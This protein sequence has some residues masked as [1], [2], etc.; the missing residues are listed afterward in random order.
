MF[1]LGRVKSRKGF[2]HLSREHPFCLSE[3]HVCGI[4]AVYETYKS[5]L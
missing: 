4:E 3:E 1:F 2:K 5:R